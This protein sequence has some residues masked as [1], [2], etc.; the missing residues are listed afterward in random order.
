MDARQQRGMEIAA[1]M[2]LEKR[3]DGTWSV[4]SQSLKG[5][6]SVNPEAKRCTCPDFEERQL[7]CKHVFAV[8][9]VLKRET[10]TEGERTSVTET[11]SVRVTYPQN[12]PAYNAAQTTEKAHFAE[13]LHDLCATVPNIEQANGRKS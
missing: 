9:F 5:R 4:P 10:V 7:P 3:A 13:L 1:T 8:D 2:N 12:W 6:Y 11:A